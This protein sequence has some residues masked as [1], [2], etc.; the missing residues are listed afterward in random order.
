[1]VV[2]EQLQTTQNK[3]LCFSKTGLSRGCPEV[4]SLPL[5]CIDYSIM[6]WNHPFLG[7][8]NSHCCI[9]S[10]NKKQEE[11]WKMENHENIRE[12]R[13]METH[14][15]D[16]TLKFPYPKGWNNDNHWGKFQEND[17]N[18]HRKMHVSWLQIKKKISRPTK[19]FKGLN[20][21]LT[22]EIGADKSNCLALGVI[23]CRKDLALQQ[24]N[25]SPKHP[26]VH[27]G[28]CS[29]TPLM[30]KELGS[31]FLWGCS[32]WWHS[33]WPL[34]DKVTPLVRINS[35]DTRWI[36]SRACIC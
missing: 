27:K 22:D 1:M 15:W 34:L 29:C 23:R 13:N 31:L 8:V 35:E 18:D 17:C 7:R 5:L 14:R 11:K 28:G 9:T 10:K 24:I 25:K 36:F 26:S 30:G 3:K 12:Y 32:Y 2:G 21:W 33:A 4:C 16:S 20:R 6:T 19:T